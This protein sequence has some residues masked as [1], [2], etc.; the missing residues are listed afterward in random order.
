[1]L[2]HNNITHDGE[3]KMKMYR[4]IAIITLIIGILLI[5]GIYFYPKKLNKDYSGVIYRL[6]DSTYSEEIKLGIHGYYSKG[7]L[8]GD[9]Y[10]GTITIG[11]KLL[12][13][14]DISF[15]TK[16]V[17]L[18]S[19]Y[20]KTTGE[21]ISYGNLIATNQMKEF[22]ICV[23]NDSQQ[24]GKGWSAKHGF[25]ISAPASNRVESLK[26]TQRL[27]KNAMPEVHVE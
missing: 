6:G 5:I 14:I 3:Q 2:R 7:L 22:T 12:E 15:D 27:M 26:L 21:Y 17:G 11:D 4:K 13:K 25:M 16:G 23:L 18:I 24:G 19:Y 10:K 9:H 20:D 1:M 8:K